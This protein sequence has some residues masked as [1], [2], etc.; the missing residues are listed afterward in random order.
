MRG[1]SG[2]FHPD[3][4]TA[5]E[6]VLIAAGSGITPVMSMI[7]SLAGTRRISL[8]YTN[9]SADEVI[10]ADE[11]RRLGQEDRLSVSHVLTRDRGRLDAAGV[12]GWL[13]EVRPAKDA[14]YYVCGPEALRDTVLE[15][16]GGRGVP[17]DHVHH[18]R[19]TSG[20][21]TTLGTTEPQEMLVRNG[22]D[23]LGSTVVEPGQ[24][25]LDAGLAAGLPM[26]YSCTVGN[27]GDCLVKL[28]DGEVA[29]SGPNCLTPQQQADGYVLACV[30]CPRSRVTLD[31]A[32]P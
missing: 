9:R 24:T 2:A 30:G 14:R 28:C 25:L 17:G 29:L 21:E 3:P 27:C 7:R 22:S 4:A 15:V 13:D 23:E 11:L 31:L 16:L 8:L 32:E 5:H 1:P 6:L 12:R 26:P 20:A 10:F 18:E 19:Y